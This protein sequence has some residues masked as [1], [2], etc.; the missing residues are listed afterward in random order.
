MNQEFKQCLENGKIIPFP[1]GKELVRKE[2]S[3]A[4][5]DLLDARA[6]YENQRYK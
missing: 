3:V 4:R 1:R 2:M 6:G 5:N